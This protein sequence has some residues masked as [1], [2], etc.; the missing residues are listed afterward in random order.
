VCCVCAREVQLWT[1]AAYLRRERRALAA[2]IDKALEPARRVLSA[3]LRPIAA[4]PE[5]RK[6]ADPGVRAYVQER[7]VARLSGPLTAEIARAAAS[8]PGGLAA[9]TASAEPPPRA[10]AQV[11]AVLMGMVAVHPAPDELV[12][13]PIEGV[14]EAAIDA[15][16]MAL[17]AEAEEPVPPPP[18]AA[19]EQRAQALHAAFEAAKAAALPRAEGAG[20]PR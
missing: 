11:R 19:V 3:D 7:L 14:V 4:L 17:S 10:A 12:E 13:R 18:S 6:R 20:A 8:A 1:S 2:A 15:F 9:G 5:E 16:A